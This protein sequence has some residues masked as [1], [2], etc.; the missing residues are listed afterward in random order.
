MPA[1]GLQIV[2]IVMDAPCKLGAVTDGIRTTA[3]ARVEEN[4]RSMLREVLEAVEH[5]NGVGYDHRGGRVRPQLLRSSP[6]QRSLTRWNTLEF[7]VV[8]RAEP[9]LCGLLI[10]Q[11]NSVFGSYVTFSR[12]HVALFAGR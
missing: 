1:H 6:V 3:I 5:M 11:P 10:E 12:W 9:A 4:D 2:Y 8:W 7:L